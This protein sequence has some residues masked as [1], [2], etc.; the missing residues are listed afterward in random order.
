MQLCFYIAS[1]H[2]QYLNSALVDRYFLDNILVSIV[3]TPNFSFFFKSL[4]FILSTLKKCK[5]CQHAPNLV[6][7]K[8]MNVGRRL[9]LPQTAS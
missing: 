9:F 3:N 6:C 8:P 1:V 5:Y 7:N 4:S 2:E